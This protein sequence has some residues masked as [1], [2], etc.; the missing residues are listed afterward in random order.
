MDE[1]TPGDRPDG[2]ESLL[3]LDALQIGWRVGH[4]AFQPDLPVRTVALRVGECTRTFVARVGRGLTPRQQVHVGRAFAEGY[5][6]GALQAAWLWAR[7]H[8]DAAL[9]AEVEVCTREARWLP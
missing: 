7:V 9:A 4:H 8:E 6:G 3:E 1:R 2:E 5:L